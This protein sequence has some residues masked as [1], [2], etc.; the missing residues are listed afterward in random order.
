LHQARMASAS[1][2]MR[3]KCAAGGGA[4]QEGGAGPREDGRSRSVLVGIVKG[5]KEVNIKRK[6]EFVSGWDTSR[7]DVWRGRGHRKR[8]LMIGN[9]SIATPGQSGGVV[10]KKCLL[11]RWADSIIG[12][13]LEREGKGHQMRKRK[14][15]NTRVL[16]ASLPKDSGCQAI[17]DQLCIVKKIR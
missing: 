9:G 14:K 13:I 11:L 8:V 4:P 2:S 12:V 16:F 7:L 5:T 3:V 10:A 1:H 15:K 17:V 6:S